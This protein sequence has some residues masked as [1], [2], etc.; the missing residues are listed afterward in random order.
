[1]P[2]P[3]EP[4]TEPC[5]HATLSCVTSL[6]RRPDSWSSC[7]PGLLLSLACSLATGCTGHHRAQT[8]P[9]ASEPRREGF[10]TAPETGVRLWYE[11]V[12]EPR[13]GTVVFLNGSDANAAM[14]NEEFLA[15]FLRA[16]YEIVRYDA[17]DNGRSEWLP[18]P[19]SFD[20]D[21]WTPTAPPPYPLRAHTQDLVGLLDALDLERVH[22]IGVSMGGMV[23]QGMALEH[24]QRVLSLALLSTSPSNS[25]DPELAPA[26]PAF[27]QE[28]AS[29]WARHGVLV[30]VSELLAPAFGG[31]DDGYLPAFSPRTHGTG[32]RG[33]ATGGGPASGSRAAQ[34]A[35][36][37]GPC[38]CRSSVVGR[39]PPRHRSSDPCDSR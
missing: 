13:L 15:P 23:A 16:G 10:V 12:G 32:S 36:S 33:D 11:R 8:E 17:R 14:W 19:E 25:F 37:P 34:S 3:S 39:P 22:L 1:M 20:V 26:D 28:L 7:I 2:R 6:F 30:A 27:F 24:P 31:E 9:V 18:W 38:D 35:L 29:G 21:D 5:P 4:R